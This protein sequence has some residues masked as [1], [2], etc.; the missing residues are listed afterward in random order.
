MLSFNKRVGGVLKISKIKK[1]ATGK[2]S[3]VLDNKEKIV[4][5][6]DVILKNNLLYKKEIDNELF[7]QLN[8]DTKYYDI[9]NKCVKLISIRLR[10]EKEIVEYLDKNNILVEQKN[11]IIS[12][13][14][15][16]GLINDKQF[17]RAFIIDKINFSNNGPLKIKKDLENHNIDAD[18]INEEL[19]N[20]DNSMYLE[21]IKK[22]I[23]KKFKSNRK[24]SDY[25]LKQKIMTD[26][27]TLGF[28]R[29]DIN[30]CL[31][32]IAVDN[33]SLIEITY[34]KLYK[35]L[36]FKYEG[37]ELKR[38]LKEKLY[39]KGFSLSEIDSIINKKIG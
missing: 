26:L 6:D 2:Y 33:S 15:N 32:D 17:T 1:N 12:D 38:K 11:K 27:T 16:N 18:I 4:T 31:N 7:N 3:L 13:L 34:D 24:Y 28:Y 37:N 9:Y 8:S 21:K 22:I 5:Y 30:D 14:K 20:I 19:S 25:I 35:K 39:Q 10:S 29:E 23:D 36:C